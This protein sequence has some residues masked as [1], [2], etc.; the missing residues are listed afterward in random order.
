MKICVLGLQSATPEIIFNDERLVNLR[1]LM[2][3]GAYGRMK[4][5]IP[6]SAV[7]AWISM[8]TSQDPGSLGVY[9]VCNRVDHPYNKSRVTSTAST[10]AVKIWDQLARDGKKSIII[11]VPL[12]FPP[13][14]IDG[15]SVGCFLAPDSETDELIDPASIKPGIRDLV[16]DYPIDVKD[17]RTS[18]KAALRDAI[19]SMSRKQWQVVHWLLK[20]QDWDYFQYVDIGLDRVHQRF[21][22]YSDPQHLQYEAGNPYENVIPDYYAWLDEQVGLLMDSL[23]S[24]TALLLASD[25]GAQG[26]EGEFA[27]NQ[28]LAEDQLLVF[29]GAPPEGVVPFEELNVDWG[30]TRSWR[31]GGRFA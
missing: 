7:P 19:F 31:E 25:R 18:D 15:I 24:D 16:G 14:R 5:V 4:S 28:W 30:K 21:W 12:T 13:Q 29:D 8:A 22:N 27:I 1:R 23:P 11:G 17:F 9:G 3:L 10:E 26:L 6:S 20:E 2:D